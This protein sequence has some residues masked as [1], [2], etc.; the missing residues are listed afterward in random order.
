MTGLTRAA[1]RLLALSGD[2][3]R[4]LGWAFVQLGLIDLGLRLLGFD[5]LL[6][7]LSGDKAG[8]AREASPDDL[9]DAR[10]R[11]RWIEVASRH[12][13]LSAACLHR[14]LVLHAWLR[15]RRLPSKL[16]I[17]VRKGPA[18][19]AAHAWVELAGEV[20][21]DEQVAINTFTRL[22]PR[23]GMRREHL[24]EMW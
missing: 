2:E 20:V 17:G 12:H 4:L 10:E 6:K 19:L 15:R 3:R 9:R 24:A 13:L 1:R 7:L 18:G 11:A 8:P 16:L 23:S 5:R 21:N 14:S 22:R